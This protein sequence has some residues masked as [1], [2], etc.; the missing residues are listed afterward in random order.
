MKKLDKEWKEWILNRSFV[1]LRGSVGEE[2]VCGQRKEV[3]E[4]KFIEK[5]RRL[6]TNEKE[7]VSRMSLR[8]YTEDLETK[9]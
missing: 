3:G 5:A 6:F 9:F 4:E 7:N 8:I 2:R 1:D